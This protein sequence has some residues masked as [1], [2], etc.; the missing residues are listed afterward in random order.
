[1]LLDVT[2]LSL[3]VETM[4][5]VTTKIIERNTTV[6]VRKSETFSTAED[7]QAA[8]DIHVLQGERELARDNRTLGNFRLEGIRPAPRGAPQVEVSYDIDAN[9]ILT[10]TAKDKESGKE[11]KITISGS[12]QLSKEEIDRM[13]NDAQAHSE[14]DR[15][16]REEVEARNSADSM[17]YQ[18][19]RQI[20]DLGD[21]VPL[22]E[23]ARAEQLIAEIRELVKDN[24][25]D[26]A[27]LRK[28]TGDLQQVA[29]GLS[30]TASGQ[31]S[32]AGGQGG[33]AGGPQPGGGDDVIDAEF[34]PT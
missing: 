14:D 4:G 32:S 27:R 22:N 8:V 11:Q 1:V 2:P 6:P 3:G 25:S 21:R 34:K 9:G 20:R 16:R 24:S 26:V 17:A 23:K 15:K 29:Y 18:V 10:V 13:V 30:S 12:T 7:N 31:A 5:G 28:L 33:G 19:E